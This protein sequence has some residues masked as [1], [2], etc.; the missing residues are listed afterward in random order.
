[1]TSIFRKYSKLSALPYDS[2]LFKKYISQDDRDARTK[3]YASP[4]KH[5]VIMTTASSSASTG[6]GGELTWAWYTHGCGGQELKGTGDHVRCNWAARSCFFS[7]ST[8]FFKNLICLIMFSG[9]SISMEMSLGDGGADTGWSNFSC[10]ILHS[11]EEKKKK[12]KE[13]KATMKTSLQQR[14]HN[15][16]A[17]SWPEKCP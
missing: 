3:S 15:I 2:F 1:M 12:K 4:I 11:Q 10:R 13:K 8:S 14:L 5:T 9:E 7:R 16:R 6:G 17:E